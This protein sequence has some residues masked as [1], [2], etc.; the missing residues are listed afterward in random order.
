MKNQIMA[1]LM[2]C[3][4]VFAALPL[5]AETETVG[6]YTWTDRINGGV[7]EVPA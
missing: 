5:V 4:M 1:L 7:A 3:G 6:G 2:L